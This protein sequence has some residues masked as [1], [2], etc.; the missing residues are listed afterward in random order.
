MG[1]S[2]LGWK[3]EEDYNHGLS[4]YCNVSDK[5]SQDYFVVQ[6]VNVSR[7]LLLWGGIITIETLP[8]FQ[9]A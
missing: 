8:R 5:I 6:I 1:Q 9:I 7:R 3:S 2:E 4:C